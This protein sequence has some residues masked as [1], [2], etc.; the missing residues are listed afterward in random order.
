MGK[1]YKKPITTREKFKKDKAKREQGK[2][3]KKDGNK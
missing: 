1:S 2:K 3:N